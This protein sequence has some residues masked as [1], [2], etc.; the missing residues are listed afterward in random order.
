M[1]DNNGSILIIAFNRPN[2]LSKTINSI[3]AAN[4]SHLRKIYVVQRGNTET[5]NLVKEDLSD[6]DHMLMVSGLSRKTRENISLNRFLGYNYA[7]DYLK[8]NWVAAFED[9]V[10]VSKDIFYFTEFIMKKYSTD[11]KFRAINYGSH[12]V[13][14][15]KNNS[16]FTLLRY[17]LHGPAS[18]IPSATW[19]RYKIKK[20]I[21]ESGLD[22]FDGIFEPYIR[23]GFCITPQNSRF[24][25]LGVHGSN[26]PASAEDQYFVGLKNSFTTEGM[27]SGLYSELKTVHSWRNDCFAYKSKENFIFMLLCFF[28]ERRSNLIFKK[29]ERGIY[30]FFILPKIF[31]KK[32]SS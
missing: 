14:Q 17:G 9:D 27:N 20:M 13:F 16:N 6:N 18:A 2:L 12:E 10:V 24:L 19:N 28:G 23:T 31:P 8:S 22:F 15:D 26:T 7:F 11:K 4:R 5:E 3:N 21:R 30:K 32:L 1:R 25:D 29:V